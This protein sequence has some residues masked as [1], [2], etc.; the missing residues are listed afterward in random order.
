MKTPHLVGR[1][2]VYGRAHNKTPGRCTKETASTWGGTRKGFLERYITL[3]SA[4]QGRSSDGV[5]M[6]AF[7]T[8]VIWKLWNKS[9]EPLMTHGGWRLWNHDRKRRLGQ[10]PQRVTHQEIRHL[11]SEGLNFVQEHFQ[12]QK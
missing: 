11:L 3:G 7:L 4:N 12:A 1:E 10:V 9:E 5:N 6:F 2:R 8:Q